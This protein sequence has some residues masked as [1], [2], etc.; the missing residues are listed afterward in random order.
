[1]GAEL[2]S[3]NGIYFNAEDDLFVASVVG[4]SITQLDPCSG[5]II[6]RFG[7][8]Q[9]VEAPDDLIFDSAG[10]LYWT[11]FL[12]GEVA[13]L[14]PEGNK[15]TLAVLGPGVN[16]ITLSAD[17]S[18]L[19][20]SRI[21]LSDE[22]WE[23]D[24]GGINQ[25]RLLAQNIGGLNGMD[26][27]PDGRLYGPLWYH[28]QVV[29]IDTTTGSLQIVA[30]DLATPAA[31]KFN[32]AGELFVVD[33][34][35]GQVLRVDIKEGKLEFIADVGIGADNLAFDSHD[36]M[37]VTNTQDSAIRRVLEASFAND[38]EY[39][40]LLECI[41]QG[42]DLN[43]ECALHEIFAG[44]QCI[45]GITSAGLSTSSGIALHEMDGRTSLFIADIFSLREYSPLTGHPRSIA[46][47]VVGGVTKLNT[48]FSVSSYGTLL[49]TTSWFA[50]TV[51]IWDPAL[52]DV[53]Y[54]YRDFAVP[55]NAIGF[56]DG[57]AVAEL[58]SGCVML[59]SAG[60]PDRTPLACDFK[61]PVGLAQRN[62]NLFVSDWVTGSVWQI[63][64]YH[65]PMDRPSLIADGLQ[66]PEGI[67]VTEK[68]ILLVMETGA[69]RLLEIDPSTGAITTLADEL[70]LGNRA[71][72]GYPPTW[73][74]NSVAVDECGAVFFNADGDRSV[75][76][77]AD[78]ATLLCE[79]L[80]QIEAS[81]N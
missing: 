3:T 79:L 59:Q 66:Q 32:H 62:G 64:K 22:L 52:H 40:D 44:R 53:V 51:Q 36:L 55:L 27:G 13:R 33:Q 24:L 80:R 6:T 14:T 30:D 67:T 1:M 18:K 56:G 11:A 12:T 49:L 42:I 9:G 41:Y 28:G 2:P 39:A 25:P 76:R 47:S 72:P 35:R 50:N 19:Y 10:N 46:H 69:D 8:E 63:A 75:R 20:V 58:G 34:S 4:R 21:F 65:K 71:P 26:I 54:E 45:S 74:L 31:V 57:L 68:G 7:S 5:R 37:Y 43:D 16:A 70:P 81:I 48:P 73:I 38:L 78:K 61:V 15:S 77:I 17:E 23:I 60:M 29:S